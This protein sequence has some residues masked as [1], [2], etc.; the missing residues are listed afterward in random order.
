MSLDPIQTAQWLWNETA[1]QLDPVTNSR[2]MRIS[3]NT[4]E[5]LGIIGQL[6]FKQQASDFL[7]ESA[8]FFQD[9]YNA[10]RV[11]LG[12]K[13]E[14]MQYF[15]CAQLQGS[16]I[17]CLFPRSQ[18]PRYHPQIPAAV[19][20][21]PQ[22]GQPMPNQ[23]APPMP[24]PAQ[25]DM[26]FVA[27]GSQQPQQYQ[28]GPVDAPHVQGPGP[29]GFQPANIPEAADNVQ[30]NEDDDEQDEDP[31][32]ESYVKRPPNSWILY[33][34]ARHA[35][36]A[37]ENPGSS[38]SEISTIVS[39]EWRDMSEAAKKPW[40]DLAE[41]KK[42][43]HRRLH[44]SYR[45]RPQSKREKRE[46]RVA[47]RQLGAAASGTPPRQQAVAEQRVLPSVEPQDE[48]E[49]VEAP[50]VL[51][52]VEGHRLPSV[53]Q[54]ELQSVEQIQLPSLDQFELQ[55]V[56]QPELQSVEQI[57]LPSLD[58]FQLQSVEQIDLPSRDE[59]ELQS[60]EQIQ[61]P[62]LGEFELHSM[63]ELELPP[64][65]EP[66]SVEGGQEVHQFVP[67]HPVSAQ[68]S[69]EQLVPQQSDALLMA[70]QQMSQ[71]PQ[72]GV[73]NPPRRYGAG[74]FSFTEA[75][76]N[77]WHLQDGAEGQAH[78]MPNYHA[79]PSTPKREYISPKKELSS[80]KRK[81]STSEAGPSNTPK[82]QRGS[83]PLGD[84]SL[85]G[86]FG[87]TPKT[88]PS[89]SLPE[90]QSGIA[91][92]RSFTS[93]GGS[94][95]SHNTPSTWEGK[96]SPSVNTPPTPA[97]GPSQPRERSLTLLSKPS[98]PQAEQATPPPEHQAE[99][100]DPNPAV[101]S[102]FSDYLRACDP[103]NP[104]W[105]FASFNNYNAEAYDFQYNEDP[106]Y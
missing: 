66:Q 19:H 26:A 98:T 30:L 17:E 13:G 83:S 103:A 11:Y 69:P 58:Q 94:S 40:R 70:P 50:Q 65:E 16:V 59:S 77:E 27:S 79:N 93:E 43:E 68:P 63:G 10:S 1:L 76:L 51:G 55:S 73:G 4:F 9:A 12:V 64:F 41:D 5:T 99:P 24:G 56:E 90:Y 36:V 80:R 91:N 84:D 47:A 29:V 87:P 2:I 23:W 35:S 34:K 72:L 104:A 6:Y 28:A 61:L 45:F 97:G 39:K 100:E 85:D 57:Q 44:P 88:S 75:D 92:D 95:V 18:F 96:S 54:P 31:A 67:Q 8:E 25:H 82:R 22:M 37:R 33:R 74:A 105:D 53:E 71:Q 62:S 46:R 42:A 60:V 14:L 20:Y 49:I 78:S 15:N 52:L 89:P 86:L 81:L 7:N 48:P 21:Y 3:R 101:Y 38:N 106:Q 102:E 32:E